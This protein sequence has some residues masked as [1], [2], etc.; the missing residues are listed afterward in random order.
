V[1]QPLGPSDLGY[2]VAFVFPG[3]GSQF[4]GMGQR[5]HD[6]SESARRVFRQADEALG[7]PL[8]KLCFEGPA[9]E[10]ED[11]IN[12]QPA[13]LTVSY[14]ALEALRER[15]RQIGDIAN[16]KCVAGHS[17]GEYT[18]L[19]SAGVLDFA[20][21]LHLVRERGRLMKE[22]G[23]ERP[24]GMAAV[25]GLSSD[26]LRSVCADASAEG[27]IVVVANDNCPGQTVI[28]GEIVALERAM[29]MAE[30]RGAKKV[31][32]LGISI[33]SHS[34]LM[35]RAGQQ[36]TDLVQ[37]VSFSEPVTPIVANLTGRFV[38]SVDEIK[39]NV[40]QQMVRPVMWSSSV[41]EMVDNGV[42]TFLEIGPGQVLGGLIRRVK[43]EVRTL[44]AADFGLP[45]GKAEVVR[46][47]AA[48]PTIE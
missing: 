39:R 23:T 26:E 5:L 43:R 21:A 35:D 45:L 20:D 13:I 28:S 44:T 18:A 4:V 42:G 25:M 2:D 31:V 3:Q 46:A 14:A 24:G 30:L 7:F 34:P 16:P 1:D 10:L 41:L 29:A 9:D 38:T 48:K 17:L 33:A 22:A 15:W 37:K 27:G 8:S 47:P 32:R 12:S 36:L 40:G 6:I 19:V 11:T